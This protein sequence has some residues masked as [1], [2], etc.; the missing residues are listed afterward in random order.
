MKGSGDGDAMREEEIGC[1]EKN[2][3][4]VRGGGV[5]LQIKVIRRKANYLQ[6]K[7]KQ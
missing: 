4:T 7:K 1:F 5:T 6:L 3:S 2:D